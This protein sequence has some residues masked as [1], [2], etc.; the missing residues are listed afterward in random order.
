MPTYSSYIFTVLF[1]SLCISK[2]IHL[3]ACIQYVILIN[4]H[5]DCF[6]F[7]NENTLGITIKMLEMYRRPF[8]IHDITET[9]AP[10][11]AELIAINLGVTLLIMCVN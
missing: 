7:P 2:K 6:F 3:Y 8:Q 9:K 4:R 5:R 1:I 10:Q 11:Y